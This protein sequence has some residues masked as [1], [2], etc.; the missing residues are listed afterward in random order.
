MFVSEPMIDAVLRGAILSLVG[1]GWIILLVRVNGLRSFSKMTSFDFVTT[2]AMGSLLAG[3]SQVTEASDLVQVLVAMAALFA[4]QFTVAKLRKSSNEVD[5]IVQNRP[6]LLVRDGVIDEAAL[7]STRVR[8]DDLYAKLRE[9]NVH[10]LEDVSAVVLETTG[11]ISVLHGERLDPDLLT[12]I[13]MA[14]FA[15]AEAK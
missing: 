2:V 11:S 10:R 14:S 5:R 3:C 4:A 8:K 12:G 9:A 15:Q 7:K 6:T 1:L 13:D